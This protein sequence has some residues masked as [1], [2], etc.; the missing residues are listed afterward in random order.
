MVHPN[1]FWRGFLRAVQPARDANV[2]AANH[3]AVLPPDV[4][5]L[6]GRVLLSTYVVQTA[7][8][9]PGTVTRVSTGVFNATTLRTAIAAANASAGDDVVRFHPRVTGTITLSPT[10]GELPITSNMTVQGPGANRLAVSAN[11]ASRVFTVAAGATAS[12][13]DLTVA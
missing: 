13:N 9:G 11:G 10:A 6:E 8:D 7:G 1:S 2:A 4:E 3:T 5:R 12:I